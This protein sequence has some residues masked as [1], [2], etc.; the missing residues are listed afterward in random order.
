MRDLGGRLVFRDRDAAGDAI[1]VRLD[2]VGL[3]RD[4]D[5]LALA[6]V[7]QR[8]IRRQC[9]LYRRTWRNFWLGGVRIIALEVPPIS[10]AVTFRIQIDRSAVMIEETAFAALVRTGAVAVEF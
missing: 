7:N 2:V 5:R 3:K 4:D 1:Q 8:T 9:Q 10:G 6:A